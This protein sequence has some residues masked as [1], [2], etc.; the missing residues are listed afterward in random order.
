VAEIFNAQKASWDKSMKSITRRSPN[1]DTLLVWRTLKFAAKNARRLAE[2]MATPFYAVK[3]GKI[4]DLN[5]QPKR[6]R[7]S[8]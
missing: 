7:R 5:P 1:A 2:E 3:D 6:R 8:A 4:V